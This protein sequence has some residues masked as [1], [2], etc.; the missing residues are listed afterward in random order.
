MALFAV[1]LMREEEVEEEETAVVEVA[2]TAGFF[3]CG[4]FDPVELDA[5]RFVVDEIVREYVVMFR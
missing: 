3:F 1:G 4:D 5:G 2:A